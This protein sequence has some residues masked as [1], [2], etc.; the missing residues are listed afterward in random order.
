[1]RRRPLLLR[2][3]LALGVLTILITPFAELPGLRSASAAVTLATSDRLIAPPRGTP[4]KV[5]RYAESVGATRPLDTRR[6]INEIYRLAPLV[7]LDPAIVVAQSSLE[8]AGWTSSYWTESLNPAGIRITASG[9]SSYT[10]TTGTAAA[11]YHL[12]HLYIYAA[13]A[14]DPGHPLYPYRADG[15]GYQNAVNLGYG[16]QSKTIDDLT[17]KWAVDLNY[18]TKIVGRGNTIFAASPSDPVDPRVTSIASQG[19][20]GGTARYATDGDPGTSWSVAGLDSPPPSARLT[21]DLGRS[22]RLSSIRWVFGVTGRADTWRLQISSNGTTWTDLATYSNATSRIWQIHTASGTARYVRFAFAN[23]NGDMKLGGF[24]EVEV[25]G[26]WT[27]GTPPPTST[28]FPIPTATK[29]PVP[30]STRIPTATATATPNPLLTPSPAALGGEPLPIAGGGGSGIGNW[31]GYA[32]D[33][34]IQTTW[35]TISNTPP[36]RAQVYVDL[37]RVQPITGVEWVFRRTSGAASYAI[38]VSTDKT[39]WT[40]MSS[41][42]GSTPLAWQRF[43]LT[44]D[45]RYVRFLFTNPTGAP[46]LG[47]VAEIKVYGEPVA[48]AAVTDDP[49]TAT[50]PTT[51]EPTPTDVPTEIVEPPTATTAAVDLG[52][53]VDPVASPIG[54]S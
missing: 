6:Y 52:T 16:G 37:G 29:T 21:V 34:N 15:P 28:P 19:T 2:A 18:G 26:T 23:P 39:T 33:G 3:A 51:P 31:S 10:W 13:G 24:A 8:T 7:G 53:P 44:A 49:A 14:I 5:I 35:R 41:H 27:N 11:R 42:A 47:W 40:P 46:I 30:T 20:E 1:M 50:S 17:G 4:E 54:E 25:Y 43:A 9:V 22:H 32:R 12:V 38:E 48:G 45:A 36:S